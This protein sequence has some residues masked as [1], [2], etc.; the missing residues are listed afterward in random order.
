M[1]LRRL[2]DLQVFADFASVVISEEVAKLWISNGFGNKARSFLLSSHTLHLGS[3]DS[4]HLCPYQVVL[5]VHQRARSVENRC[6]LLSEA[7]RVVLAF[8][9]IVSEERNVVFD[10]LYL[11]SGLLVRVLNLDQSYMC[12]GQT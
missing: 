3:L 6:L 8:R 4:Q 5:C 12:I 1:V 11:A 2:A 10:E 9:G 7:G